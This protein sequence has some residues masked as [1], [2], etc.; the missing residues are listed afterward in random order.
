VFVAALA[1]LVDLR[2][3]KPRTGEFGARPSLDRLRGALDGTRV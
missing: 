2:T 3:A 1:R